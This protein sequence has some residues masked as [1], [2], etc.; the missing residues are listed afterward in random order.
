MATLEKKNEQFDNECVRCH[1][2]G[3]EKGGFQTLY[4]TPQFAKRPVRAVSRP[5]RQ[6]AGNPRKGYGFVATPAVCTQC[7]K[8]PNDPDFNFAVYWRRLNTE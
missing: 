5:G 4:T 3:F 8:E 6:H 7:H 2:V 1:V